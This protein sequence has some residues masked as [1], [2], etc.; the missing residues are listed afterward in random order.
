MN[1]LKPES[2]KK[3]IA[4][5]LKGEQRASR[6]AKECGISLGSA[7]KWQRYLTPSTTKCRCGKP[8]FHDGKCAM[9]ATNK[10][11]SATSMLGGQQRGT[12]TTWIKYM[13][14]NPYYFIGLFGHPFSEEQVKQVAEVSFSRQTCGCCGRRLESI[15]CIHDTGDNDFGWEEEYFLSL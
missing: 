10:P 14:E 1:F 8:L 15:K 9:V 3:L 11:A 2:R 5:L 13:L 12:K 7:I 6:L 4:M